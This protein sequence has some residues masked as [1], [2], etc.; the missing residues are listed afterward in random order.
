MNAVDTNIFVYAVDSSETVKGPLAGAFLDG[1]GPGTTVLLWQVLCEFGSVLAKA[2]VRLSPGVEPLAVTS[3]MRARF[4]LVL[5][6]PAV[7]DTG[8][9]LCRDEGVSY[10]DGLLLAAC[11]QAGVDTLF[12]EDIPGRPEVVGVRIVDPLKSQ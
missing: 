8:M 2:R 6:S 1:L 3:L 12:S 10:W 4:P 11:A 7:F 9:R 5:P